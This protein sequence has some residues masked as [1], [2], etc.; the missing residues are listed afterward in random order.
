MERALQI[1]HSVV[2]LVGICILI[3]GA[4]LGV[5]LASW[6]GHS[7][8]GSSHEVP[9]FISQSAGASGAGSVNASGF[10]PNA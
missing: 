1:R 7:V 2:I 10:G 6:S 3:A 4:M 8:L 9:V 5:G